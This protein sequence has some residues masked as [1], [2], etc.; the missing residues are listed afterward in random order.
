MAHSQ[1][2]HQTT[3]MLSKTVALY[4]QLSKRIFKQIINFKWNSYRNYNDWLRKMKS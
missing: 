4:I 3:Q 1:Y 2:H